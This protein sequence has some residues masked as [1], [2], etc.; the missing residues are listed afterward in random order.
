MSDPC[1]Y[2]LGCQRP[3]TKIL[4][5]DRQA[6]GPCAMQYSLHHP[7]KGRIKTPDF[8]RRFGE[9]PKPLDMI[10]ED[11]PVKTCGCGCGETISKAR[12]FRPGHDAKL[13]SRLIKDGIWDS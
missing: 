9:K 5:D 2:A 4:A 1:E 11:W 3:A 10:P 13:K 6:C 7:A 12:G 8:S